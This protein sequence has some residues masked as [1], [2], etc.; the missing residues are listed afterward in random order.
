MS[1]GDD[2]EPEFITPPTNIKS[3]VSITPD[4]VDLE[5]LEKAEQVIAGLQ[6]S[7]LDWVEEDLRNIQAAYDK[8]VADAAN[9][10]AY[11]DEIFR[12]SHDV[13][14][15]GGSFDY[16]LMTIIGNHLCRFLESVETPKESDLQVIKLHIDSLRVVITQRM[17]GDGGAV[18]TKLVAGIEAVLTKVGK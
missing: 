7:Y 1:Q 18:G 3:K 4:G 13:K 17:A 14:G 12:I 6:D 9:R 8:A 5:A 16:P 11:F 2:S 15:Q 10:K